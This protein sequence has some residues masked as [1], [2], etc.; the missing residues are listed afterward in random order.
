[1]PFIQKENQSSQDDWSI[2]FKY[3]LKMLP[4]E[5]YLVPQ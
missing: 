4:L 2:T 3:L 1:M 5:A